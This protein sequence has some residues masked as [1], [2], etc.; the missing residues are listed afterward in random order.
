MILQNKICSSLII[1]EA[2]ARC[3]WNIMVIGRLMSVFG[4]YFSILKRGIALDYKT[5]SR[6]NP[7]EEEERKK[8]S[9][10][11]CRD[12]FLLEMP[13]QTSP[14]S[15]QTTLHFSHLNL[16]KTNPPLPKPEFFTQNYSWVSL[17]AVFVHFIK[18]PFQGFNQKSH[19]MQSGL[20]Y[21]LV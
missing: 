8:A 17:E 21:T 2:K 16:H 11:K 5:I 9:K 1:G 7:E 10:R 14:K 4:C 15:S 12:S 20:L 3:L 6:K 19:R 13:H 18:H